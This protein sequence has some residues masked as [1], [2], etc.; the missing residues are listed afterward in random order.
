M[1]ELTTPRGIRVTYAKSGSGPPLV[2]VHGGFSDHHSNWEFV[3]PILRDRF[4]L[5]A[6]ARRNRGGTTATQGHSVVDEAH[7][8]VALMRHVGEPVFLLGHSYGGQCALSAARLAPECVR[9]LVLYEPAWPS[10]FPAD[11]LA[12]LERLAAAGDWDGFAFT[13]FRDLMRVPLHEL[14]AVRATDL[15]PPIVLD[16]PATL[17]DFRAL[18]SHPFDPADFRALTMPV[19]LQVGTDSPRELFVTDALAAVL[20]HAYVSTL[21]G[22]AHEAMTTAPDLYAVDVMAFLSE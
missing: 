20:P 11:M 10:I 6:I 2:L 15:W 4:T 18:R 21:H 9:K 14:E 3:E 17:G 5:Y 8:V 12:T 1:L 22:Q 19:C 16:G 13:F 7:D